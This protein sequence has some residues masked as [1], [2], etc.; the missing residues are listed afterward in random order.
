MDRNL[1]YKNLY[2]K[3]IKAQKDQLIIK[4]QKDQS[5]TKFNI[6]KKVNLIFFDRVPNFGDQL[7]KF[8]THNLIN[9]N[10]Y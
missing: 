1:Y 4:E 10:E 5:I 7:S 8:I 3:N 6:K 2:H 9:H